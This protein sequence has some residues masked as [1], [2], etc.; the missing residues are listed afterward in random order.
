[1]NFEAEARSR[2]LCSVNCKSFD[3]DEREREES[4][5]NI[6]FKNAISVLKRC[7]DDGK[8][9]IINSL[10]ASEAERNPSQT[11]TQARAVRRPREKG[12]NMKLLMRKIFSHF[13]KFHL[14]M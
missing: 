6:R 2:Q 3:S 5:R 7:E 14:C 11:H 4:A 12:K 8:K 10:R 9:E 1:M 13:I